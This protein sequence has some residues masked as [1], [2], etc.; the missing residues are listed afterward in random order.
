MPIPAPDRFTMTLGDAI[1]TMRAIRRFRPDPIKR[2]DL[3]DILDAARQAPSGGN[4]Q[5]WRFLLVT[6]AEKRARLG[7]LY[8]E[9]WWAKRKDEGINGP[10][11]IPAGKGVRQSA[12]RLAGEIGEAPAIALVC[13]TA[14]GRGAAESVI[15]AVQNLLLAARSLGVGGTITTLHAAVEERVHEL[16]GIPAGAQVV[17]C[18]PLGYP[19]GRFGP[20]NRKPLAE[21]AALDSWDETPHWLAT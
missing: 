6:D 4:R 5:G 9:A 18:V 17:Y 14:R 1:Y 7:E 2:D 3:R 21:V 16:F 13:A 11:D 15:P 8:H 10:E 12:M 19:R 20:L